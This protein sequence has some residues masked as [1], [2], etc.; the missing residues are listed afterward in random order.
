MELSRLVHLIDSLCFTSID[1]HKPA[2]RCNS[3]TD[4]PS[5]NYQIVAASKVLMTTHVIWQFPNRYP[6]LLPLTSSRIKC[7]DPIIRNM[8]QLLPIPPVFVSQEL[9]S[10]QLYPKNASITMM[11][12]T[13]LVDKA[14][15]S[16]LL[17][18]LKFFHSN[19]SQC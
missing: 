16:E 6:N 15:M 18:L 19:M 3:T 4:G 11:S 17:R 9:F 14:V 8:N 13:P 10:S 5:S 12:V 7:P 2:L 1:M